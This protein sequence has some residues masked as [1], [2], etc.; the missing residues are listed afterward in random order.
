ME[1][2][3]VAK[4]RLAAVPTFVLAILAG[5]FIAFGAIFYTLVITNSGLGF[6]FSRLVGGIA[7]SLGLVLVVVG[8]ILVALVYW[9]VYLKDWG[10]RP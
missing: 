8:A 4:A 2:V 9:I 10:T 7:F 6:G 1:K 5:A 3:G